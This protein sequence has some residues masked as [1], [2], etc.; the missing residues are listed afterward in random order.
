MAHLFV[1]CVSYVV[2]VD[3]GAG[4]VEYVVFGLLHAVHAWRACGT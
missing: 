3:A 1:I 2:A 4:G